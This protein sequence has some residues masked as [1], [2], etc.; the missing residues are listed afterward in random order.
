MKAGARKQ[1]IH[2][3]NVETLI[4]MPLAKQFTKELM[5]VNGRNCAITTKNQVRQRE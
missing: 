5:A 1:E 2:N 4:G 3:K